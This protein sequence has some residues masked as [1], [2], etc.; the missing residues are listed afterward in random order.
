MKFS[1]IKDTTKELVGDLAQNI[2]N[3]DYTQLYRKD[4]RERSFFIAL[5][6]VIVTIGII[7]LR[8]FLF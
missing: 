3:F 4:Q 2:R 5:L 8:Y 6:P 1:N 7:L